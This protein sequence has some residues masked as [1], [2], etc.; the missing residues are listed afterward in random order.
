M[1]YAVYRKTFSYQIEHGGRN[2]VKRVIVCKI[3]GK[4]ANYA[5]RDAVGLHEI[6]RQVLSLEKCRTVA[7]HRPD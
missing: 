6:Y 2:K 5:L 4:I 1:N 7:R 3:E